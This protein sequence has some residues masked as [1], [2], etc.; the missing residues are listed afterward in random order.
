MCPSLSFFVGNED[1]SHVVDTILMEEICGSSSISFVVGSDAAL[2]PSPEEYHHEKPKLRFGE[3]DIIVVDAPSV[4]PPQ[5]RSAFKPRRSRLKE[6]Y[7]L[8]GFNIILDPREGEEFGKGRR[9]LHIHHRRD[10]EAAKDAR[11]CRFCDEPVVSCPI[12]HLY[13]LGPSLIRYDTE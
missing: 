12:L 2:P 10:P 8:P 7:H 11:N 13:L 6:V 3:L 9:R 5:K 4:M 1:S